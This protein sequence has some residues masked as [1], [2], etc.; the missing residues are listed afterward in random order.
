MKENAY[1]HEGLR[2]PSLPLAHIYDPSLGLVV[3]RGAK[4]KQKLIYRT[5]GCIEK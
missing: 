5:Q 4:N 1:L 3:G 2:V